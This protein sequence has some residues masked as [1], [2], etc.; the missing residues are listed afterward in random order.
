MRAAVL[1][2]VNEEFRLAEV[3][4][5][6]P[7]DGEVLVRI[8]ASG[9]CGSDLN[10]ISGKRTL[11]PFP[12]VL[13]HEASGEVVACGPGV[14]RLHE[15]D[16]VVLSILPWCGR[17]TQCAHGRRNFCAV[18]GAA[19][20]AGAL[21]DG[22]GRLSLPGG[23][24]LHHFLTV[25]SFAPYA[26]VPESGAVALPPGLPLVPAALLSCA[27]LTGYGAVHHTAKVRAGS[28]V[29]VFGCGGVGL[30]IVQ[31]ARLA[32]AAQI[33]AVDVSA[34]KLALASRLG[35]TATVHAGEADPVA[36][37]RRELDGGADYAFEA[38]GREQVMSQA[39]ASL[40]VRG[41][42][43]LVGLLPGG[44]RL[45][46][47]AGPFLSEQ[48]VTGCY[49]G[50]ADP[51]RDIPVLAGHYLRGELALDELITRQI[52]LDQLGQGFADLRAG[53]GARSV[54]VFAP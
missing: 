48:S 53:R 42:L 5:A 45:C 29:A 20:A 38:L 23:D 3:E 54:L 14:S 13:G 12:A 31:A 15:G 26:V 44:A 11:V 22:T 28:R 39:W 36:A 4:L 50:S 34:D 40:D 52:A 32:G 27:V 41:Q 49:L 35:A 30:N 9:L 10:A 24:T 46:L 7:R 16:H 25:S 2:G 47:D 1:G 33:V 51:A 37:V 8:A 17:C 18:A 21:L 43:V 6:A 19:M